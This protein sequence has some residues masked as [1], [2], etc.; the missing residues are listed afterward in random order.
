MTRIT[1]YNIL[2]GGYNLHENG[3]RR[4]EQ[5]LKIIRSTQPDVVGVV[6]ATNPQ[7]TQKPLVVEELAERLGMQLVMGGEATH[8]TD[9]QLALLT[10]L[11]V[12]HTKIH[13]RPGL[14]THPLLEVC[15]EE[16]NGEHLTIFVTHLSAAFSKG[17]A[18]HVIR[19]REAQ[20]IVGI[21]APLREQ[22]V[23]HVLLGDFNSLAPGDPFRASFLL[24]YV[25]EQDRKKRNRSLVDGHPHL[26]FVV[27]PRLRFLTP[28]LRIIPNNRLLS[29]LFDAA[30]WFYAPRGSIAV[31]LKAGYIDCY[32]RIHPHAWGFTCPASAPAGRIDYIFAS[33][34]LAKRLE[35]CSV[36]TEGEDMLPGSHASD[37]LAVAATF[38]PIGGIMSAAHEGDVSVSRTQHTSNS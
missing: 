4:V 2:A 8:S 22:G 29:S 21:T 33:P 3:R 1:S 23:P 34:A 11:P 30:A 32:R 5:L 25:V 28:L 35:T 31:L 24:R 38:D 12:V 27:P 16:A 20:E 26:D 17:W 7:I 19:M 9:Y 13:A 14:F 36:I 15:V 18:G 10:R 37:H 6:E